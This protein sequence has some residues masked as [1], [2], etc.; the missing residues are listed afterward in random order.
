MNQL[1][2]S[3]FVK[4]PAK[5]ERPSSSDS[6]SG[7]KTLLGKEITLFGGNFKTSRRQQFYHDIAIL[8]EAGVDIS[9]SLDLV[10]ENFRTRRD[11]AMLVSVREAVIGG[12]SLSDALKKTGKFS[13]YEY[14]TV[15]IG[16]ETGQLVEILKEL[17]GYFAGRIKLQKKLI[18]SLSYPVV[19]LLTA[20]GV[21][22]FMISF[23]VPM[24][25]DVFR[26]FGQDL[27]ALT[28]IIIRFSHGIRGYLGF[29]FVFFAGLIIT[30]RLFRQQVWFRRISSR[31]ILSIPLFGILVKHVYLARF[32]LCMYLLLRSRIPLIEA[33]GLV[34][35][36]ICFY[37]LE[38]SLSF[39]S[40]EIMHGSSLNRSMGHFRIYEK[41]M[42]SMVKVAEE[43]NQ[44]DLIFRNLEKQYNSEIEQKTEIIGNLLE[45]VLIIFIGLFVGLILVSMYLP[46]FKLSTSFGG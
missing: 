1:D 29:I 6:I 42:V 40:D 12:E 18:S 36:M 37:P 2:I 13:E 20:F 46:M 45:P 16:E 10:S 8:L 14:F 43:T 33:L 23:I 39:I 44:L 21:I 38:Y 26:R 27:P 9:S 30:W 22:W 17:S 5:R 32:S 41:R 35:E 24:F 19:V 3:T 4:R 7:I 15:R 28:N 25:E 31:L 34:R 11:R